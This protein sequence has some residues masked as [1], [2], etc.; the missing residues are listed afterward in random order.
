MDCFIRRQLLRRSSLTG[1]FLTL[2][3]VAETI[4][5]KADA[6]KKRFYSKVEADL[7]DITSTAFQDNTF[8]LA[9]SQTPWK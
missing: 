2:S 7:T 1:C 3:G 6:L 4:E 9:L 5:S 8:P